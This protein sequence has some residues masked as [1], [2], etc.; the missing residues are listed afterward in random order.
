MNTKTGVTLAVGIGLRT[1]VRGSLSLD[2]FLL[3]GFFFGVFLK[4]DL[5]LPFRGSLTI[6]DGGTMMFEC[7][8]EIVEG[9]AVSPRAD[10]RKSLLA[11]CPF[12]CHRCTLLRSFRITL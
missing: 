4:D 5:K 11:N 3:A 1:N 8:P 10:Q 6:H 9:I 12:E 7:V 2:F